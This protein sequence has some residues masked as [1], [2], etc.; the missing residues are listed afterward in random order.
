MIVLLPLLSAGAKVKTMPSIVNAVLPLTL[1][2]N[3][4]RSPLIMMPPGP[5]VIVVAGMVT[6]ERVDGIVKVRHPNTIC[7]SGLLLQS[8][9]GG[10]LLFKTL[11][12]LDTVKIVCGEVK[13]QSGEVGVVAVLCS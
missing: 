2:G 10:E 8:H 3:D 4:I 6:I 11:A 12:G 9:T 1:V 13:V 5:R 7:S